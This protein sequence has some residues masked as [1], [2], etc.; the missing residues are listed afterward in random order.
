M[1]L[2]LKNGKAFLNGTIQP[3]DILIEGDKIAKIG[4]RI[5]PGKNTRVIDISEKVVSPGFIDV[6]V[7][8]RDPGLEYKE[9]IETGSKAAAR[10]GFTTICAMPNTKPVPDNP[11]ALKLVKERIKERAV[12]HVLPYGAITENLTSERLTDVAALKRMDVFALSDDGVGVQS[13]RVMLEAMKEAAR[14]N[15]AVVAHCEDNSLIY[16]GVVHDGDF[17]RKHHLP[18]IPSVCESVQI[19]RDVLLAEAAGAHYHVCHVS[20]KESVRVI[21]DAKRAGIHVTAEATPHHLILSDSDIPAVDTNYKMNPPLRAKDD[22]EALIEGLLDGTIDVIA[23]D[24]APHAA[25]EKDR[26]I[27][28]APFGIVGSETA[29]PLLY[30]HL[31]LTGRLSLVTLLDKMA[32]KPAEIF[33]LNA[34]RLKVGG[35]ADV[36]V[37]D[38]NE[39]K[40]IDVNEFASKGRNTP[41]DKWTCRGWPVLTIVSGKIV[42][43]KGVAAG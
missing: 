20:T 33:G 21:R 29:F 14:H 7:H 19:A 8:L 39:E 26:T 28:K 16:G 42:C 41:F 32:A 6:H 15:V 3:A 43:E 30:T 31:V 10:G 24:H 38:L 17:A 22:R 1:S 36:T 2:L 37:L 4:E 9:T 5:E 11:E 34:G 18:G 27:G 12:I 13:A 40:A 25:Y 23:T 35:P